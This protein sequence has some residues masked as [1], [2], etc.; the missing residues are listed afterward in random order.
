MKQF[1]NLLANTLIAN[2]TTSFL[3]FALTFWAYLETRSVLVTAIIGGSYMLLTAVMGIVFGTV[4]DRHKKKYIM[5]VSTA[6]TAVAYALAGLLYLAVPEAA[7][8]QIGGVSFWVLVLIILSGAIVENIRNITLSTCV[9][10]MVPKEQRDR[11]N[12]LVGV[13]TGLAFAITSVFSGLVIGQLGMGW[14]LGLAVALTGVSLAHLWFVRI[15]E[16]GIAH[17]PELVKRVDLR[18]AW[19]AVR[20]VPGLLAL[21]FFSTFNNLLGGVFMALMDPYGLSLVS[22]EAWGIMWGVISFGFIFGGIL[23][24][25][26]GLGVN[27][28]R[29]LLL[30]NV[31]MWLVSIAFTI[32]ESVWLMA[33][34]MF[35]YM[36]L[37]P[38]VEA[39][40]QTTIQRVVPYNKQGR[41]F[42]LAQSFESAAAPITAF[43]IGPIAEFGLIP[44]M[45]STQGQQDFG[46]LLGSGNARGIALVFVVAGVVGLVVTGLAFVSRAYRTLSETYLK[47]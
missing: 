31:V 15:P 5:V 41:V 6:V 35:I 25:R 42:G 43:L 33:S 34:G 39:A 9:T 45:R 13:V 12:G 26:L 2:V 23:V 44:Y 20:V 36:L 21:L 16:A 8:L 7:L 47:A 10:L 28:L 11:A 30:A 40:E 32:R 3:W 19:L 1:Y 37:I 24:A 14:A 46:W 27:P 22:V 17:D 18:G 38:V 29:L 4:V